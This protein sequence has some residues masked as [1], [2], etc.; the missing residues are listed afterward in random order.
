M[1]IGRYTKIRDLGEGGMGTVM[2]GCG[3]DGEL[4][5]IKRPH[6]GQPDLVQR[7]IDEAKL[8]LKIR[9]PHLVETMDLLF[10]D[11]LPH[12]VV[13]FIPGTNLA[14]FRRREQRVPL[15]LLA[16]VGRQI[17]D[18]LAELHD[19][20]TDDGMPLRAV[21]RDVTPGNIIIDNDGNACLIDLGIA[22][23]S[24]SQADRTK[25]GFIR[26]TL[27]YLPP[28][29]F[30]E[31]G[32]GATG[33]LWS[34]GVVVLEAAIAR[35]MFVGTD[36]EV[37]GR[38]L[39][40]TCFSHE[41]AD[42]LDPRLCAILERLMNP[43]L[44]DRV[45]SA[46]QAAHLFSQ[47]ERGAD[48][49]DEVRA[50]LDEHVPKGGAA[51]GQRWDV[52]HEKRGESAPPP[53]MM[54]LGPD[55]TP[56][57][58]TTTQM[59]AQELLALEAWEDDTWTRRNFDDD[60]GDDPADINLRGDTVVRAGS[61]GRA[62]AIK[63]ERPAMK[64]PRSGPV[65]LGADAPFAF[66]AA[67]DAVAADQP[68]EHVVDDVDVL[69]QESDV[70]GI[71]DADILDAAEVAPAA[72]ANDIVV[73]TPLDPSKETRKPRI[74]PAFQ[75]SSAAGAKKKERRSFV[76]AADML[77]TPS[78]K[79]GVAEPA[80]ATTTPADPT[81]PGGQVR[82]RPPTEDLQKYLQGLRGLEMGQ[83]TQSKS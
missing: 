73:G 52:D 80:A 54:N 51:P 26:G 39:G 74:E 33:D 67:V 70:V 60:D 5:V 2:L 56:A 3:P 22:R 27:R 13:R 24:E 9:H 37:V 46:R 45:Q 11:E 63:D 41:L 64:A 76:A 57:P 38:I 69:H 8:G 19:A 23:S 6:P 44:D 32:F 81:P 1:Q 29:A 53:R 72:P 82:R 49:E 21:H 61:S 75:T 78:T 15:G 36:L 55:G 40:F 12:L 20:H 14:Q 83:G 62:Q 48:D 10:I 34:L 66:G 65:S 30:G 16:R 7:L 68:V 25:T 77:T 35:R 43:D 58:L 71:D 31:D 59:A 47:L 4:V 18:A 17:A 28:E 50:F 42:E 79:P